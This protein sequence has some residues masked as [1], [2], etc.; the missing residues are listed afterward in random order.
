MKEKLTIA[1][2]NNP[3]ELYNQYEIPNACRYK[4]KTWLLGKENVDLASLFLMLNF[5]F[6]GIRF[7]NK[8]SFGP[9]LFSQNYPYHPVGET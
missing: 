5:I 8:I 7:I 3:N 9:T 2:Y 6:S 1:S 4:K